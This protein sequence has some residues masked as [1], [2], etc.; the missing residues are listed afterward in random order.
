MSLREEIRD[1]S[2]DNFEWAVDFFEESQREA[3]KTLKI[4]AG[5]LTSLREESIPNI[6]KKVALEALMC[7]FFSRMKHNADLMKL[8]AKYDIDWTIDPDGDVFLDNFTK[9][10]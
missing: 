4:I 5:K 2:L 6:D 1:D 3:L 7:R 8:S 10:N 9:W